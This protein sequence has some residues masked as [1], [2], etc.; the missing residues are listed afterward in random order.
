MEKKI[1]VS[2][3]GFDI[4]RVKDNLF[5]RLTSKFLLKFIDANI[6]DD[7]FVS[8][9]LNELGISVRK[10]PLPVYSL[11]PFQKLE[12]WNHVLI[13]LPDFQLKD[14]KFY[15]GNLIK[16]LVRDFPNVKFLI[17]RNSGKYFQ[18][19]KNVECISWIENMHEV[20]EKSLAVI[21]LPM[22]DAT[23]ATIIET[24]SIGRTMIAS[25]TNFPFCEK[26]T[27]YDEL[28]TCLK[29]IIE[30]PKSN[31]DGSEY[32]HNNYNN[33]NLAEK[34]LQLCYNIM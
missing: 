14:F 28:Q 22:H 11:F 17:T 20:Y 15:Q 23:G 3:I 16:K 13:Y 27:N 9:E 32:V 10:Q 1:I 18:D 30:N 6:T 21:R 26:I 25:N 31:F 7:E 19:D 4:R 33:S 8:Q 2:W 12:D 24:L 5:W 34:L 29:H